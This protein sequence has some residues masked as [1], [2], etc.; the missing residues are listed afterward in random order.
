MVA[1]A[2]IVIVGAFAAALLA[3][4][5]CLAYL[6]V[7]TLRERHLRPGLVTTEPRVGEAERRSDQV[8]ARRA[9]PHQ[10]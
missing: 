3:A 4:G 1:L 8:S 5:G 7:L 10:G 2:E 6:V 9:L